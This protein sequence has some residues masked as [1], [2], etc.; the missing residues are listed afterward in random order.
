M[1]LRHSTGLYWD[2]R[3][4]ASA[5]VGTLGNAATQRRGQAHPHRPNRQQA[6]DI[7]LL[8]TDEHLQALG[9]GMEQQVG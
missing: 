1:C 7:L 4:K 2:C 5:R 9:L 8:Q 3:E 6:V